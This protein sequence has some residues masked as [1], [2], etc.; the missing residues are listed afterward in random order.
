MWTKRKGN[1]ER[2]NG[3]TGRRPKTLLR[4]M[5][6][7]GLLAIAWQ[8]TPLSLRAIA[9]PYTLIVYRRLLAV[10]D[11]PKHLLVLHTDKYQSS[12]IFRALRPRYRRMHHIL[13]RFEIESGPTPIHPETSLSDHVAMFTRS[14]S[15]PS[16]AAGPLIASHASVAD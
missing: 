13:R 8:S 2:D 4:Q 5:G 11:S 3:G 9:L 12:L 6:W 16:F 10:S 7:K 1:I 14:A 15:A